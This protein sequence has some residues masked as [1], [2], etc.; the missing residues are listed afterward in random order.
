MVR[1]SIPVSHSLFALLFCVLVSAQT[2]ATWRYDFRAGDHLVYRYAIHRQSESDGT[3]T[4]VE[5]HFRTHVVVASDTDGRIGLGFQRNRESA[6]LIEYRVK[7]KDK[8]PQERLAFQKRMQTRPSLFSE[9]M[10][11]STTGE[12]QYPWEIARETSSHIL[13]ALHEVM[14]LPLGEVHQGQAW[15]GHDLYGLEAR[16]VGDEVLHG[17][18]CHHIEA[19]SNGV[20]LKLSYWWSPE[21]G[22][23]EKIALDGSY[24]TGDGMTHEQIVMDLESRSR[25]ETT[26]AWLN[27]VDTREGALQIF[28]LSPAPLVSESQL[29]GVLDSDD[30]KAQALAM[31]IAR[32]RG[33]DLPASALS[34][35]RESS[36]GGVRALADQAARPSKM[37]AAQ[38]DCGKW[39]PVKPAPQKFGTLLEGVPATKDHGQIAYLLRV[40]LSYRPDRPVPLLVYLSGGAGQAIDGVN[41]AD[42]VVSQTDY[43]VLYPHAGDYWW[44]PERAR[45]FDEALKKVLSEYNVDRDRIYI[46]GFS[47]GG[48]G[49]LYFAGLWPQRFAAVVTLMGAGVCN[50]QV[51]AGLPNVA[52]LPIFLVHGQNDTRITPDCS[53][54]TFAALNEQS[55]SIKPELKILNGREHDIVLESD[56]G[57]TLGFFKDKLRNAFPKNIRMALSGEL[58]ARDY[59]VEILHGQPGKSE[60]TARLK[61]GNVIEVHSHDVKEIRLFLRPE[62]F[63]SAGDIHVEWNGKKVFN[64]PLRDVCSAY[65]SSP[66]SVNAGVGDWKLDRADIRDLTL[67]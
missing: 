62:L 6:E 17:R 8:L 43:L 59:W 36:N 39:A 26:D 12:S 48:T 15:T 58:A 46:T 27:S 11:V 3:S 38:Q 54:T 22:V 63:G 13:G 18:A 10:V 32:A 41:T 42:D 56:D 5:A 45:E 24:S 31:A 50:E 67:P 47:N 35:L 37:D 51:K 60:L 30:A 65:A 25:G 4:K 21:S 40:P 1:F 57:L 33:I 64:G 19:S 23:L 20:S 66:E 44:K 61:T 2:P 52:N 9:A 53:Q 55:P 34:K 7:G 14:T 49:A 16:W 28:L 29:A